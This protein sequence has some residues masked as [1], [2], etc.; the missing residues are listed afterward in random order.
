MLSLLPKANESM[1]LVGLRLFLLIVILLAPAKQFAAQNSVCLGAPDIIE[2]SVKH[3]GKAMYS[4]RYATGISWGPVRTAMERVQIGKKTY[5]VRVS[6]VFSVSSKPYIALVEADPQIGPWAPFADQF[7]SRPRT[8]AFWRVSE[9]DFQTAVEQIDKAQLTRTASGDDFAYFQSVAGFQMGVFKASDRIPDP[10]DGIPN[11]PPDGVIDL[12]ALNH[13]SIAVPANPNNPA[14]IPKAA[15][16]LEEQIS[17]ATAG[18]ITWD[19][20]AQFA[21]SPYR[22]CQSI[23]NLVAHPVIT[24]ACQANPFLN[25]LAALPNVAPFLSTTSSTTFSH[26]WL[27]PGSGVSTP[28]EAAAM[29]AIEAQVRAAGFECETR[30]YSPDINFPGVPVDIFMYFKEKDNNID[31]QILNAAFGNVPM[32][33]CTSNPG[34]AI[35]LE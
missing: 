9:D 10:A 7:E 13:L 21:G 19:V 25:I 4:L 22:S 2:I 28:E 27:A 15:T 8:T 32:S 18:G 11:T 30:L 5:I 17:G 33:Q 1:I 3:L 34:C 14:E 23:S 26:A 12:G 31:L 24:Y 16:L 29:K 20:D 6:R 35:L